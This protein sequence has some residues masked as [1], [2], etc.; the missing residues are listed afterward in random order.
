MVFKSQNLIRKCKY[1]DR[2]PKLHITKKGRN[3]GYYRTC[4]SRKCLEEQYKDHHVCMAKGRLNIP[5]DYICVACHDPFLGKH[6]NHKRYCSNCAPDATWRNRIRRYGVGKKLWD[7]M[8]ENQNGTCA[9]C[10]R[11]PEVVDHCPQKAIV[12][13]LLCGKCNVW[14]AI[15]DNNETWIKRANKYLGVKYAT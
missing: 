1:C 5:I 7:K 14:L 13:G 11:N 6:A 9:I 12:R 15:L 8:L 2:E 10:D 3:K 4:G